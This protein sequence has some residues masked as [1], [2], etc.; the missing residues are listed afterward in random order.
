VSKTWRVGNIRQLNEEQYWWI[1]IVLLSHVCFWYNNI[2]TVETCWARVLDRLVSLP[3][4]PLPDLRHRPDVQVGALHLVP[5]RYMLSRACLVPYRH[6]PQTPKTFPV[7]ATLWTN[8]LTLLLI[9]VSVLSLKHDWSFR[10]SVFSSGVFSILGANNW[11][12]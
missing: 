6:T 5:V 1:E 11:L 9:S 8:V 10:S 7:A 12:P 3:S 4:S 2:S